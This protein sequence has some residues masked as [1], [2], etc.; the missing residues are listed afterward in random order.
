MNKVYRDF[1]QRKYLAYLTMDS[2]NADAMKPLTVDGMAFA[3]T[4]SNR[5]VPGY[6]SVY[7][8]ATM[9]RSS[10]VDLVY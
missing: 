7:Y 6:A 10:N 1:G 4:F 3:S 9:I 5:A 2:V 8:L